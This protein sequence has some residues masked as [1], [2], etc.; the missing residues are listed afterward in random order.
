MGHNAANK[1][2]RR[3]LFLVRHAKALDSSHGQKDFDRELS[4]VGRAS[5]LRMGK[6]LYNLYP[7]PERIVSSPA[8]R[9][10]DS[11]LILAEQMH[12]STDKVETLDDLYEATVRSLFK[13]VNELESRYHSVMV[14]AHNPAISYFAEYL[15]NEEVGNMI[16]G[17]VVLLRIENREWSEISA[18][19]CDFIKYHEPEN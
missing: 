3:T 10:L 7:N 13:L 16:P 4:Q 1:V 15:T 18:G 14:V 12:F 6:N 17:G 9:A 8:L 19:N 2:M 11:A 5:V